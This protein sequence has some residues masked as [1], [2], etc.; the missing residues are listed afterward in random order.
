[1]RGALSNIDTKQASNAQD[2][3]NKPSRAIRLLRVVRVSPTFS[4]SVSS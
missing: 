4:A 3:F 2:R 1:L